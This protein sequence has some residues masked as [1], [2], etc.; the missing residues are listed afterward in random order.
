MNMSAAKKRGLLGTLFSRLLHSY[1]LIARG[2]TLGVRAVVRSEAGEFLLVRHTYTPGWHF[3]GGGVETGESCIDALKNELRQ[4][5]GLEL[6]GEPTFLGLYFNK[7]I[8]KRDHVLLYD[9]EVTGD[10]ADRASNFE[11]AEVRFFPVDA[12]PDDIEPGTRKRINEIVRGTAIS[13]T[14]S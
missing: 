10:I 12:L 7:G 13:E 1:F 2:L 6:A 14:W 4:E 3:P 11:I 5:A 8:S 9:C